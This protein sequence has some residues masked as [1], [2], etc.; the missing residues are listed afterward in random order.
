MGCGD[1]E[2]AVM[3]WDGMEESLLGLGVDLL[4]RSG[5]FLAYFFCF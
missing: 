4:G 3:G 1:C 2:L 5:F